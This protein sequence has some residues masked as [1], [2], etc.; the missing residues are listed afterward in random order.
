M[1]KRLKNYVFP[2]GENDHK[3]HLFRE[4]GVIATLMVVVML[5]VISNV[6]TEVVKRSDLIAA[7]YPAVLV[8]LTNESRLANNASALRFNPLLQQSAQLKSNDMAE[9]SYF[10]HVSPDGKSPWYWFGQVGYDFVYAGENLAVDF[11]QSADVERAWMNSPTHRANILNQ[12]FTEIGIAA[13]QGTYK[14]RSTVFVTQAFG[15][16]AAPTVLAEAN[17]VATTPEPD[18]VS[19]EP[20]E[21]AVLGAETESE[22]ELEVV[23]QTDTF[24]SVKNVS[25]VAEAVS[26]Q[27]RET[28][29]YS[30][31][32]DK[33]LVSPG[34]V[35]QYAY[36]AILA[37][38]LIALVLM[39]GIEIKKQH[40]KNIIYGVFVIAVT[41]SLMFLNQSIMIADIIVV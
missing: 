27:D 40:P 38:V 41:L 35:I 36:M 5:F 37:L 9:K 4:H 18:L 7:I 21:D 25:A 32:Y 11:S 39:V 3:P 2:H 13:A 1:K 22:P 10:A 28:V 15:S 30:T 6:A 24:V 17:V 12:N 20:T 33:L 23:E 34:T 31:W 16:P 8:D 29:Q 19:E 14:G 26:D